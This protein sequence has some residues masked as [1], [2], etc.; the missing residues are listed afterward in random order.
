MYH[1]FFYF[2]LFM[3]LVKFQNVHFLKKYM[4]ISNKIVSYFT[5]QPP[6]MPR[7]NIFLASKCIFDVLKIIVWFT[8]MQKCIFVSQFWRLVNKI[9]WKMRAKIIWQGNIRF[10]IVYCK[11]LTFWNLT[12][13][14]KSKT[15]NRQ[16]YNVIY[17]YQ[18]SKCHW[19]FATLLN[20]HRPYK[21]MK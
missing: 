10:F 13:G 12:D 19:N 18:K 17:I 21:P 5:D 20:F 4:N 11:K 8:L 15:E 14:K 2:L 9:L 7:K 16:L 6:E 3:P 1:W